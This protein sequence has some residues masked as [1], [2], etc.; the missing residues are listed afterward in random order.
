MGHHA[1]GEGSSSYIVMGQRESLPGSHQRPQGRRM[2]RRSSSREC[3]AERRLLS[4]RASL[5]L[6]AHE[7]LAPHR[8][9]EEDEDEEYAVMSRSISRDAFVSQRGSGGSAAG[10]SAMAV[11][12][13]ETRARADGVRG[14][15]GGGGG[16]PVDS[17][18]MAMLPGV[19]ASPVSLSLSVAVSDVGAKPG[20]D[21][22]YMAMTP[23]NSVSPPQHICLPIS[24]GYMV[25]SPTAAAPQTCMEWP[26]G[27]AGAAWRA[28]L[29]VTT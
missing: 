1:H 13:G 6:A 26:C 12:V 19:T 2:L 28:E 11:V 14:E 17:G 7:R 25:M 8:K 4:K 22:E 20:A 10:G 9:E 21:D 16:A 23:N 15:V 18:Y 5:P 29:A 3:E 27:G 24:E